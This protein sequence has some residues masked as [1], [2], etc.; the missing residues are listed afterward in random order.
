M[1]AK[2]LLSSGFVMIGI[3]ATILTYWIGARRLRGTDQFQ[4][5]VRWT[6]A[7][8]ICLCTFWAV[9]P[10]LEGYALLFLVL[11]FLGVALSLDS[12]E[13]ISAKVLHES[14]PMTSDANN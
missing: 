3:I 13:R 2:L 8:G 12:I 6:I 4:N 10:F 9:M 5:A 14:K 1:E 7:F 11:P